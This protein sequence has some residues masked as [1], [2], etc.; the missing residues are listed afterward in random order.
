MRGED[1]ASLSAEP[2]APTLLHC[3]RER[4]RERERDD[5]WWVGVCTDKKLSLNKN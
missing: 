1:D 3:S 2:G 5:I 4:E